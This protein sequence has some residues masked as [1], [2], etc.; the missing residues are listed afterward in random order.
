MKTPQRHNLVEERQCFCCEETES[1][2]NRVK[3]TKEEIHTER[4]RKPVGRTQTFKKTFHTQGCLGALGGQVRMSLLRIENQ[5]KK[6][7]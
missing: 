5:F 4:Q 3:V 2:A 1:P 7:K 6:T